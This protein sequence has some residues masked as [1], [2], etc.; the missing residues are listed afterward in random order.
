[1]ILAES[2]T[3]LMLDPHHAL[4]ELTWEVLT[5][6]VALLILRPIAKR[7]AA[8]FHR[9]MDKS[10]GIEHITV[11]HVVPLSHILT[12][13]EADAAAIIILPFDEWADA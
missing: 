6:V 13:A 11:E 3:D 9:D 5:T 1:M 4:F 8:K 12:P 7:L 10:H 2:Y